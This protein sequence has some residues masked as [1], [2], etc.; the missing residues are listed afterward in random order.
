M[1]ELPRGGA[2][3]MHFGKGKVTEGRQPRRLVLPSK[4]LQGKLS[5]RWSVWD[6]KGLAEQ[7]SS[8]KKGY[9]LRGPDRVQGAGDPDSLSLGEHLSERFILLP[10]YSLTLSRWARE[11][12]F[13]H[14]PLAVPGDL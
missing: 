9:K 13:Y 1:L 4:R 10:G 14:L 5:G 8:L 3:I 6:R 12:L 11:D 2:F 7:V